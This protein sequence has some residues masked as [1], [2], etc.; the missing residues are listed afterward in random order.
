MPGPTKPYAEYNVGATI[1]TNYA[2]LEELWGERGPALREELFARPSEA[3]LRSLLGAWSITIADDVR[4]MLV[5]I[6][7]ARVKTHGN[8]NPATESFYVLV[9]PPVPR[10]ESEEIYKEMQAWTGAYYHA[11]SDGYGM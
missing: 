11:G 7:S 4:I 3:S 10:R 5:D 8:I 2:F 1:Q 6:E 9:L